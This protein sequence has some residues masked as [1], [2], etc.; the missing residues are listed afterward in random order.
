VERTRSALSLLPLLPRVTRQRRSLLARRSAH[1]EFRLVAPRS[2]NHEYY[3]TSSR[4]MPRNI[5]G[6][7]RIRMTDVLHSHEFRRRTFRLMTA[8]VMTSPRISARDYSN[9]PDVMLAARRF[10]DPIWWLFEREGAWLISH[11]DLNRGR[12]KCS[13][14]SQS[15]RIR[16]ARVQT[17][18]SVENP[19]FRASHVRF[20]Y[21]S[22]VTPRSIFDY[23]VRHAANGAFGRSNPFSAAT[24]RRNTLASVCMPQLRTARTCLLPSCIAGYAR[25]GS[26]PLLLMVTAA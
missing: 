6:R 15:H 1:G 16:R 5:P 8:R 2:D 7:R 13:C 25:D 22:F 4:R 21:E 17:L 3:L 24:I 20:Q 11:V 10:Q 14:A 23:E 12:S 9:R 19:E 26:A 18:P